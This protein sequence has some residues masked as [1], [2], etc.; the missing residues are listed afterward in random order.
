MTGY[1]PFDM[2][3]RAAAFPGAP[4][5]QERGF[6]AQGQ[7]SQH[8]RSLKIADLINDSNEPE[9]FRGSGATQTTAQRPLWFSPQIEDEHSGSEGAHH[10]HHNRTGSFT[11]SA[12]DFLPRLPLA[13][14]RSASTSEMTVFPSLAPLTS[15]HPWLGRSR[16][17]SV[18]TQSTSSSFTRRHDRDYSKSQSPQTTRERRE[19]RPAYQ[20]EED[21]FIWYHRDDLGMQWNDVSK[22]YNAQFPD[23]PRIG[24]QGIQSRYYRVLEVEGVPKIRKRPKSLKSKKIR[25]HYGVI[26]RTNRRYSWMRCT[27]GVWNENSDRSRKVSRLLDAQRCRGYD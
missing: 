4:G 6:D 24:R 27:G 8:H 3:A 18:S 1:F 21:T 11:E 10:R 9:H 16:Q 5:I 22:A 7:P 19:S 12:N 2:G 20:V 26:A 15:S 14:S 23:R 17:S 13:P 25:H